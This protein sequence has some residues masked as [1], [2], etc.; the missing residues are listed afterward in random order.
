MKPVV[1]VALKKAEAMLL[2]GLIPL[3]VKTASLI[4]AVR[5]WESATSEQLEKALR[6]WRGAA[7]SAVGNA[8][9]AST[10]AARILVLEA[11]VASNSDPKMR[12]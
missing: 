9:D 3:D 8:A 12:L 11:L 7:I 4:S 2:D 10:I 6:D 1:E 5:D